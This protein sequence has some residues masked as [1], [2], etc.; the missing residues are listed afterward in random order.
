MG[1]VATATR[2]G[3]I[4]QFLDTGSQ[5]SGNCTSFGYH[6]AFNDAYE[7]ERRDRCRL[8]GFRD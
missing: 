2:R 5:F 4:N 3:D 8:R 7:P 6:R 1:L